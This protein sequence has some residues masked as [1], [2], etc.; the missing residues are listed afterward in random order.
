MSSYKYFTGISST[1][2]LA[3][4]IQGRNKQKL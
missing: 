1:N 2:M 4:K 3:G